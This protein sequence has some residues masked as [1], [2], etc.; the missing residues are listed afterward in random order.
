MTRKLSVMVRMT[1]KLSTDDEG[2]NDSE[3][4]HD[5]VW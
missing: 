5:G 2:Q 1:R 4:I 3:A